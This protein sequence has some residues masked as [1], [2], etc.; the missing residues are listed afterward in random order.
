M[1]TLEF[2][3]RFPMFLILLPTLISMALLI[4]CSWEDEIVAVY[5]FVTMGISSYLQRRTAIVLEEMV[6]EEEKEEFI[7]PEGIDWDGVEDI[8]EDEVFGYM[9]IP[10]STPEGRRQHQAFMLSEARVVGQNNDNI[11]RCPRR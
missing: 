3:T 11:D 4:Y 6:E 5:D 7:F 2:A 8:T 10:A 1:T 9:P